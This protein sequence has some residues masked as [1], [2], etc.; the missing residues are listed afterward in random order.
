[1]EGSNGYSRHYGDGSERFF[2]GA[3]ASLAAGGLVWWIQSR[4]E[5]LDLADFVDIEITAPIAA[6]LPADDA[7]FVYSALDFVG[8]EIAYEPVGSD[9]KVFGNTVSCRKCL[10][11]VT[12]L[13]RMRGNCVA[14]SALLLSILRH[15]IPASD[16][17]MAIGTLAD[18]GGHAW[19]TL[20]RNGGWQVLESTKAASYSQSEDIASMYNAEVFLNDQGVSCYS[21]KICVRVDSRSCP[22]ML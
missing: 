6:S 14:K 17:Y 3:V 21:D 4:T 10:L 18:I 2:I 12:T 13:S 1:M 16:V 19:V 7:S 22:C 11:P 20:R 15:R 8:K 9:I 5:K